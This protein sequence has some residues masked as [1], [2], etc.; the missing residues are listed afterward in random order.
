MTQ[1]RYEKVKEWR[2]NTKIKLVEAFGSE[3]GHCGLEDDPCVY[4]FHHLDSDGKEFQIAQKIA[5]WDTLTNEARKCVMLCAHCH[6]K[7][8]LGKIKLE[9]PLRFDESKIKSQ[10]NNKWGYI[11]D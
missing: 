1:S 3:C 6:R 2:R 9:N 10:K 5:S 7:V 8:H 11:P 4:D